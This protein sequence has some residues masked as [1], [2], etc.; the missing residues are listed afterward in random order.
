[1]KTIGDITKNA[2]PRQKGTPILVRLQPE[3]LLALDRWIDAQVDPKLSRPEALRQLAA[4][5][6]SSPLA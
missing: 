2:R 5:A 4:A 3:A 1:M 6:L